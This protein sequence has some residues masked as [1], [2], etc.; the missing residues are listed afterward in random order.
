MFQRHP[1]RSHSNNKTGISAAAECGCQSPTSRCRC[2]VGH[3]RSVL[4]VGLCRLGTE[5][6]T[7]LKCTK[8]TAFPP[9]GSSLSIAES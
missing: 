8:G 6:G 2:C 3:C 7:L 1:Q 9:H 5:L 4:A